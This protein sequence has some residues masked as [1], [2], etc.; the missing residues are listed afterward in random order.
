MSNHTE[1]FRDFLTE[2]QDRFTFGTDMVCT[3]EPR[4]TVEW[5]ANLTQGYI[6]ILEKKYFNLTVTPDIEGD[7]NGD[8]PGTHSGLELPQNVLD[9]IYYDNMVK[10]LNGRYYSEKLSDVI[11]EST[12]TYEKNGSRAYD[13][14]DKSDSGSESFR[15]SN[16]IYI[17]IDQKIARYN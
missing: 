10:F 16:D 5:I 8:D 4:K 1:I 15:V 11:N 14:H 13:S 6:D 2:F 12:L 9:K 3:R 17:A 7:F